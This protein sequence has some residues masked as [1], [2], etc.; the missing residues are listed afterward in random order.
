MN[1]EPP[2]IEWVGA[3]GRRYRYWIYRVGTAFVRAP[4]NYVY[5][6]ESN[7]K[8]GHWSPISIGECD[9]LSVERG[10]VAGAT[11]VH[12]HQAHEGFQSRLGEETDIR[13]K[14]K[15]APARVDL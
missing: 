4:G 8:P 15:A 3:S 7:R 5:A 6:K 11:H 14:W 12:V 1:S 13:Q 9:D 2:T 10:A